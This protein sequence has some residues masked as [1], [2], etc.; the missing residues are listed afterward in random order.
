[1]EITSLTKSETEHAGVQI[2]PCLHRFLGVFFYNSHCNQ[3]GTK[4]NFRS[5]SK[6]LKSNQFLSYIFFPD[7]SSEVIKRLLV[8]FFKQ[9]IFRRRVETTEGRQVDL[10]RRWGSS[11]P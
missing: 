11:P 7:R 3:T 6:H 1:M 5:A 2:N 10:K 4:Q 8:S 9:E